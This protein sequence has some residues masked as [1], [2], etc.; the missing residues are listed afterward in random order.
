MAWNW[1]VLLAK[2]APFSSVFVD[3]SLVVSRYTILVSFIFLNLFIAVI[4]EGFEESQLLGLNV[5]TRQLVDL[6]TCT[7][8]IQVIQMWDAK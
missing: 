1:E 6:V 8:Q 2:S 3:A 7:Y 5:H 4:F